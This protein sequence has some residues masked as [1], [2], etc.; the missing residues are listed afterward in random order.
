MSARTI[1]NT[2]VQF[3]LG[4][5][6]AEKYGRVHDLVAKTPVQAFRLMCLNYPDF[7]QEIIDD[8][9]AGAE[10]Q[11][12][13]DDE[14]GLIDGQLVMPIAGKKLYFAPVV[15]GAGGKLGGIIETVV[16]VVLL[17]VATVFQQY[18]L[19]PALVP[20]IAGAGISLTLG[21]ITTLL[22]TVPKNTGGGTGDTLSSFYFNGPA[23]T[24]QQGAPVPVVYGR[25]L[26]GSQAV[27]ASMQAMDLANAPAETGN[28]T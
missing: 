21:G 3:V 25:V 10:Y 26:I 8:S 6:L 12:V 16:G 9:L 1:D 23:N 2:T 17:V 15:E 13:V 4:G 22:S 7:R 11:F 5:K 27:S 24:Q 20:M 18:E 19:Y 14:R 28:L